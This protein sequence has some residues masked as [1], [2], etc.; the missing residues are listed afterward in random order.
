M[1]YRSDYF[2]ESINLIILAFFLSL[3]IFSLGRFAMLITYS[4]IGEFPAQLPFFLNDYIFGI[5]LDLKTTAIIISPFILGILV[6]DIL[7][8]WV[9]KTYLFLL[10]FVIAFYIFLSLIIT[11]TNYY[12]FGIF[13]TSIDVFIFEFLEPENRSEV[14]KTLLTD[15]SILRILM[16]IAFS[17]TALLLLKNVTVKYLPSSLFKDLQGIRKGLFLAFLCILIALL[18][19]GSITARPLSK[20]RA[21]LSPV[22]FYNQLM[23]NGVMA[24]YRA[25]KQR[26]NINEDYLLIPE[27]QLIKSFNIYFPNNVVSDSPELNGYQTTTNFSDER[28]LPNVV[29]SVMESF[30]SKLLSTHTASNDVFGNFKKHTEEDYFFE[31]FTSEGNSTVP[32]LEKILL[33]HAFQRNVSTSAYRNI[34]FITSAA[35]KFSDKGYKTVYITSGKKS[36]SDLDLL[37]LNQGFTEI[38]DEFT[39]LNKVQGAKNGRTWGVYDEYAYQFIEQLLNENTTQP[40][41]IVLLTVTNHS[42][43][44]PPEEYIGGPIDISNISSI[45]PLVDNSKA[46]QIVKTYQYANNSLGNFISS[47][48][49][50]DNLSENTIIAATGDHYLRILFNYPEDEIAWKFKVP[51]YLYLPKQYQQETTK[52][53][54]RFGSHRDI[55]PTLYNRIFSE[56]A[57]FNMGNDL[58]STNFSANHEFSYNDEFVMN[59]F[60]AIYS[61]KETEQKKYYRWQDDNSS[62]LT[63][64]LEIDSE[65]SNLLRISNAYESIKRNL[66]KMQL[67]T[68]N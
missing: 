10:R 28:P 49:N 40:I 2:S 66:S 50:N 11:I 42:P 51:F 44:E 41:F 30:G 43:F 53:L 34:S 18:A 25:Q 17:F 47:I 56:T 14:I 27:E 3:L 6:L 24:L 32:S 45:S 23:S 12:Y 22:V 7:H 46:Q 63:P 16:I 65:I 15:I 9:L 38:Y 5:R 35:Q 33:G 68:Q 8:F 48:K 54:T 59:T 26:T 55:F 13:G 61:D 64:L 67:D 21:S 31:N 37:F 20:H 4:D 39:I 62:K 1:S 36:W 58:L 29:L 60:G 19:R 57:Y 52:D